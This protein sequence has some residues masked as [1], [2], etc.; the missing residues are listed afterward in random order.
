MDK[1]QKPSTSELKTIL[2]DYF[3]V[4]TLEELFEGQ[5]IQFWV[6]FI[7]SFI[8]PPPPPKKNSS[9]GIGA[10]PSPACTHN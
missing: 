1:V 8:C 2:T 5:E 6:F 3:V 7:G 9:E 4:S 10:F